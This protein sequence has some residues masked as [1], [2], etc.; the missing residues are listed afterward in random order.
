MPPSF[1][2]D[3]LRNVQLIAIIEMKLANLYMETESRM[4]A[5]SKIESRDLQPFK[6]V[7]MQE[8]LPTFG[9]GIARR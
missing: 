6:N 1:G 4:E 8:P 9:Q 7:I 2:P 5:E 3:A